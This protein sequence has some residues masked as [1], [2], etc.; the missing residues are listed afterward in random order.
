MTQYWTRSTSS[1][2]SVTRCCAAKNVNNT[3]TRSRGLHVSK[4]RQM[5]GERA[6]QQPHPVARSQLEPR[7]LNQPIAL[8]LAEVIDDLISNARRLD[9]IHDQTDDTDA[10]AGGVPLRLDR[11]ETITRKERRPDLDPA[12]V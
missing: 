12:S 9:A 8:A 6:A 10:P 4:D 5:P 7:Q 11:E 2:D 3:S 1:C